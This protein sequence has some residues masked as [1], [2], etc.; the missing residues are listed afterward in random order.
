MKNLAKAILKVAVVIVL[1]NIIFAAFITI[2]GDMVSGLIGTIMGFIGWLAGL[3]IAVGFWFLVLMIP[4]TIIFV[5]VKGIKR[6]TS[7]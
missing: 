5:I 4:A 6:I 3:V 1:V 2:A 7:R